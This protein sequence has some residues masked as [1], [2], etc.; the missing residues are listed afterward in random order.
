[1]HGILS[2]ATFGIKKADNVD[3]ATL[4]KYF[5]RIDDSA[6]SLLSLVNDLL[7][8]SKLESGKTVFEFDRTALEPL[9]LSVIDEFAL[10]LDH[11][12]MS[13][14]YHPPDGDAPVTADS[15]KIQQVLRNL[16]SNAVKFSADHSAIDVRVKQRRSFMAVS[17]LDRGVGIPEDELEAV[18][19]KFI[20]STKT[21]TG[22]GGT[23]L[24]LSISQEIIAAHQGR[25]WAENRPDGGAVFT[26]ELPI[27]PQK[28]PAPLKREP[29]AGSDRLGPITDTS[30]PPTPAGLPEVLPQEP[31][32]TPEVELS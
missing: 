11:R 21:R 25:I 28:K 2:F 16:L 26:F 5:R 19:D 17:V 22:A 32:G 27:H 31:S 9:V 6:T 1:L 10:M 13:I 30:D 4:L 23:G 29:K 18:F 20:Q 3:R 24:G 8:L 12:K 7:D 14:V 15:T